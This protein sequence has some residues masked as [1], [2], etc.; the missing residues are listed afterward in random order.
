[1]RE[2]SI[3]CPPQSSF[4]RDNTSDSGDGSFFIDSNAVLGEVDENDFDEVDT[5]AVN[6]DADSA[7]ESIPSIS[8]TLLKE[9][10]ISPYPASGVTRFPVPDCFVSW[11]VSNMCNIGVLVSWCKN[12]CHPLARRLLALL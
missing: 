4:E 2:R 3:S 9:S 8:P 11:T 1:M 5:N 7:V 12:L 10:R 6:F